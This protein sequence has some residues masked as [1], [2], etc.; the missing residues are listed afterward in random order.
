MLNTAPA[1]TISCPNNFFAGTASDFINRLF[2]YIDQHNICIN[3]ATIGFIDPFS[4]LLVAHGIK[5]FSNI[6]LSKG[7]NTSYSG[8]E[9][10]FG[11][12]G[13]LKHLGFFKFCGV[14]I[15]KE[16]DEANGSSNYLPFT[17][18][19]RN[20]IMW[21]GHVMQ[22]EI[23]NKAEKL[24]TVIFP[25]PDN[26]GP[27]MMLA[28]AI[29]EIIRNSFEHGQVNEC[30]ATAQR[31]MSGDAEIAIAD[32]GIGVFNSLSKVGG[33]PSPEAAIA[34]CLQPGVSSHS[35][36][37]DS[38]WANSG[39][40]LYVVSELG[41]QFG[42]FEIVSSKRTIRYSGEE[43]KVFPS[44]IAGTFVRLRV[45]TK[46]ADY[47]PNI[48]H[49]IVAEG[50]KLAEALQGTTKSASKMSKTPLAF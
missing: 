17:R 37:G 43:R 21:K 33:Y 40:G 16:V 48:L 24:A 28:Y 34:A 25:G 15:G 2:A 10:P 50:E 31:W 19:R 1:T 38:E 42:T 29:R 5:Q 13:Y 35:V 14:N 30:I 32:E 44:A 3:F 27:A 9:N 26:A 49:N 20:Q 11:V 4:S 6:R 22:K 47:F 8:F 41:K 39:F 45:S 7:L 36:T 18:I 46:D 12:I 23:D